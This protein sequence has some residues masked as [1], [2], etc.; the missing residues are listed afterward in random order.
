MNI[1]FANDYKQAVYV[2]HVM[3]GVQ[4]TLMEAD[5]NMTRQRDIVIKVSQHMYGCAHVMRGDDG[6][7]EVQGEVCCCF[8]DDQCAL[9]IRKLI[10]FCLIVTHFCFL[11]SSLAELI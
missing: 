1:I 3:L 6:G 7:C 10:T 8:C 4:S 11:S 5:T 9:F 2:L